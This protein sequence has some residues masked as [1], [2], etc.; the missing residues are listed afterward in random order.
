MPNAQGIGFVDYVLYG[1]DGKPLAVV[2]AK[3]TSVSPIKGKE[4]A[5]LYA[6]CL[7]KEY[8]YL[9][10]VYY[11]NGYQIWVIDQL[12]YPARQVFGFHNIKELEYMMQL[13]EEEQFRF[14]N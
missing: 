11:T 6:K 12:G 13:D 9:P 7:Q 14:N 5:L 1:S 3:K 8:G 4:Q 2:E 10:I